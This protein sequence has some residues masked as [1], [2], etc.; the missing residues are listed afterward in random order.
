MESSLVVRVHVARWIE[1]REGRPAH[2]EGVDQSGQ[3]APNGD[4]RTSPDCE[5]RDEGS[6]ART[7]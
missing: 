6:E 7:R 5:R 4:H 2:R 3:A 1:R